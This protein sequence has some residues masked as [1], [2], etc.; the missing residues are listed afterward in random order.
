[1][2]YRFNVPPGW[3]VP[4]SGWVPPED[5]RPDPSWPPAPPG[6]Q[7]WVADAGAQAPQV[8]GPSLDQ[9]SLYSGFAP[10]VPDPSSRYGGASPASGYGTPFMVGYPVQPTPAARRLKP[11][12]IVVCAVSR[13]AI[14]ARVA[15]AIGVLN[16]RSGPTLADAQRECR[17]AFGDEFAQRQAR[18]QTTSGASSVIS[19]VTDIELQEA[20]KTDTGF[21]VNGVVH[22]DLTAAL[23]PTV[24][25]S[26]SLTC[27]AR[28]QDGKLVTTVKNRN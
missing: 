19:S 10:P 24:H 6:W 17:T 20:R 15:T 16:A 27:Q 22:Y 9:S 7:F 5:W 25:A 2:S 3:P 23:V 1:V 21:E 26:L 18:A 13:C 8:E 4:A 12:L 14:G 11:W 28:E